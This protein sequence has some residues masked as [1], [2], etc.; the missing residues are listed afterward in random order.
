MWTPLINNDIRL[1]VQMKVSPTKGNLVYEYNPFRNYRLSKN[2]YEYK[3]SL[4]SEEELYKDHGIF[5]A[6]YRYG[7]DYFKTEQELKAKYPEATGEF[8]IIQ[9]WAKNG[10]VISS[11]AERPILRESGELVDFITDEFKCSLE[12]PIHIVPQASYDGSVNLIIND[13][14]NI[15]RLINSRFSATGKN[16]YEIIDRKGNNDTNIYDQGEQFDIDTSLYKRIVKI[17]KIDYLGSSAGGNLKV[18]N[19]HFYFKLSDADGNETDFVGESG[20]VSVFIGFGTPH[21]THSGER[22]ENSYKNVTFAINNIDP[23]YD[24]VKVYYSR[25]SAEL[26]RSSQTEY[27]KINKKY[28][29]NNS[30]S[31]LALITGYE[32]IENIDS[33]DINLNYNVIQSSA[34]SATCQNMLFMANVKKPD[35]PYEELADLSLRFLPY[36]KQEEYK[37]NIDQNY[38][39]TSSEQG[40]YDSKFIHDKTGYWG[41]ELYRFGIVYIMPNNELTPV[42]NIRGGVNIQECSKTSYKDGQ[43]SNCPVYDNKGIR[44]KIVYDEETNYLL[45]VSNKDTSQS[46]FNKGSILFENTK[47]VVRFAPTKD[48]DI[49]YG[50]DIRTDDDTLQ[51]LKKYVKGYFFVRQNRIPT[52]LAQGITMGIDQTSYTP[53]IATADGFLNELSE[54]LEKT[55]VTT[56]DINDVNYISEGFLSRYQF[57]FKKKSSSL[58]GSILKGMTI[59]VGVVA[60]AAATV[61]TAGAAG[62]LVAGATVAGAASAGVSALAVASEVGGV[63]VGAAAVETMTAAALV[64]IGT[65]TIA[66]AAAV[67]TGT[68][69]AL[70]GGVQETRYAIGRLFAKKKLDGRNT[71]TPSGYKIVETDESRKLDQDFYNRFIPKDPSKVKVQA[72]ICP[73]Y[74]VNQAYFNQVFTGNHHVI[75][76]TATQSV[77]GLSGHSSNY[78]S[79][80]K[81]HFYIP[82]YYDMN[83]RNQYNFKIIGVPDNIKLVGLDD[84]KFRSRAGEAEEAWRYE[85]IGEDYKSERMQKDEKAEEDSETRSNKQINTDIIRGSFGPYLAFN[86]IENKFSPAETVNIYI[87]DYSLANL[88]DY[89]TI[90]MQDSSVFS[91]ISVRYDIKDSDEN[92][93]NKLTNI[94]GD[95]T[96]RNNGYS[97]ELYRG[98]CYLC[99]YTHRL[100]RNFNDPAAPYNDEIVDEY[101][102]KDHYDPENPEKYEDI[103]LGDINAI[104]L[105]M[106]VT[107]KIRS[108]YNLNIRTLD[109]S[110]VDENTMTGHPHGFY[111]YHDMSVEG[112]FKHP[113]SQIY[114]KGFA[115]SLSERWNFELP[116]VPHIKN[117]V[118]T[119]IMYSDIH[120]NDAYKNGFRVFQGNHYRDYTREYGEIVKLV[121]FESSLLCV[122][123]HGIALIP[124]NERA[125]AGQGAGGNVY[126]NT[127]NVLPENPKIISDMFG[128]QWPESVLKVSGRTGDAPQYVYGVDTIA[129]K[130]WR[131]DGNAIEC[132]SDFK[133]QEFLNNNI[134]LG[135]RELT[136]KVG[137]RNV[138]THYNA[139]KRDVM[140]TFYDNTYGF[141]EKVWNLCWNELLQKFVT[142]YSWVPSY[143]ENINNIPFSFNRETSKWV[144]KL[145]TSHTECSFAD[146][147]TLSNVIT[148]DRIDTVNNYAVDNFSFDFTYINKSGEKVTKQYKISEKPLDLSFGYDEGV[149]KPYGTREKFIGVLSLSNR[150]L[151]D[152]Q[153][154]YTIS[155]ELQ[156]DNKM[157]Y[158]KYDIRKVLVDGQAPGGITLPEDAMYAGKVVPVYGLYF[159]TGDE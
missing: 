88:E 7:Q 75:Q 144:A 23:S 3:N 87:P 74:S 40:Y 24:Y 61:F 12:H 106:W 54:S 1:E 136:P 119:R 126:I 95:S 100:N 113:E 149:F 125:V 2:M 101:S 33:S 59:A 116:D 139:F 36:L 17:P 57:K 108:S 41:E 14:L 22:D 118:G 71:K 53:C 124:V 29:I 143:M 109:S 31:C 20:L 26:D 156:K 8:N 94:I 21:S 117:W 30:G 15:P 72:I 131:T 6:E 107:F 60:L 142:F 128:S 122:F 45:G 152:S 9:T 151:P 153:L 112:T 25:T 50:I 39:I 11:S 68:V 89:I 56:E 34:T 86:D 51:E 93:I 134:T 148:N 19:Y 83:V 77:N 103:N 69:M 121:P 150:V 10:S 120:I 82:Y 52:I 46:G 91:A 127:S 66:G 43:F 158:K 146:G 135:E 80:D 98:D 99:Q 27:V 105:G 35:I 62:A 78:F 90:R 55:H 104:Q 110:N 13:G 130:I 63:V 5:I 140:F 42:F 97:W 16:T 154:F 4:Y 157:N 18:G 96:N 67:A 123:E 138:K 64:G 102:W 115:K 147:I 84:L 133:V 58:F 141:E 73:D 132:I 49:I 92:L 159:N 81:R 137:I 145:G 129:K 38:A 155:Y 70:A 28:P 47:G 44:Q 76:L 32:N 111:P 48:T 37:I 114:N 65:A 79:N 85:C